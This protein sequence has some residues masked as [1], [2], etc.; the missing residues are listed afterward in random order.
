MWRRDTHFLFV[1]ISC[2]Y[3]WN[4]R[5]MDLYGIVPDTRNIYTKC[6]SSPKISCPSSWRGKTFANFANAESDFSHGAH[7]C[8]VCVKTAYEVS[9]M[10]F[11]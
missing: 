2:E 1:L 4:K 7:K 3:A 11:R 9:F 5:W 6:A 8:D 10:D